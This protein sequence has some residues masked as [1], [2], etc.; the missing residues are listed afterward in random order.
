[1][2]LSGRPTLRSHRPFLT[3]ADGI[4]GRV[5]FSYLVARAG[6]QRVACAEDMVGGV[7][8]EVVDRRRPLDGAPD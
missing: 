8:R 5:P 6:Q 4:E 7:V 1:M 3:A 2:T